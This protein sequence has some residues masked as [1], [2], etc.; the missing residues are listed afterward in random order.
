MP[1]DPAVRYLSL[2]TY[3]RDGRE[4]RTPVWFVVIDER[5]YCF[6]ADD[7]GKIKRLRGRDRA[8][9][10]ACDARG[11]LR[12]PWHPARGNLVSDPALQ[13]R[14]Y[15]ALRARYGW[16]MALLDWLARLGG[17]LG[18]RAVLEIVPAGDDTHA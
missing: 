13:R 11:R 17:R 8:A 12:G 4:V 9:I 10:A 7:A 5:Y 6:S 14:V 2:A 1:L 3:R 15:A 18:R 16:Q